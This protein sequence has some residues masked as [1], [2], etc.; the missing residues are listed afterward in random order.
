MRKQQRNAKRFLEVLSTPMCLKLIRFKT[1]KVATVIDS[2]D[3]ISYFM[4]HF[5]RVLDKLFKNPVVG[6][7]AK[8]NLNKFDAY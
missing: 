5:V 7:L 8:P 6:Y 3:L 2:H 4:G 1:S